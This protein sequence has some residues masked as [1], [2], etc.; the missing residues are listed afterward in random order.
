MKLI[1]NDDGTWEIQRMGEM[2]FH[3]LGKLG[4]ATE[5]GDSKSAQDRLFPSLLGRPA[6]DEGED[7]MI[8]DWESLVHPDLKSMFKKSIDVV[9][10]D[11][12]EIRELDRD[13]ESE[14]SLVVRKKHADDW[15]SALNQ[16]RLVLHERHKLPDERGV[17]DDDDE[18]GGGIGPDQWLALLQCEVYGV[19]MEFLVRQV[20]WLK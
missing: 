4:E 7:E 18:D 3:M 19:I 8:E 10:A 11:L 13:G 12:V 6:I 14:Y 20:L 2:E 9:L 1:S 15:C 5:A 16:A 17:L